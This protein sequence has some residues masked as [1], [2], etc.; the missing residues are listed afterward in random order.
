[1]AEYDKNVAAVVMMWFDE[2]RVLDFAKEIESEFEGFWTPVCSFQPYIPAGDE[3]ATTEYVSTQ[4]AAL[5]PIGFAPA[6]SYVP[7]SLL[8]NASNV[9]SQD[10]FRV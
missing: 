3:S 4:Q 1:M 6:E 7:S 9:R 5:N 10:L 2:I 8:L